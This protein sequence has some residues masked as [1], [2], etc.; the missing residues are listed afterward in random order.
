M[1]ARFMVVDWAPAKGGGHNVL[2]NLA[3]LLV[4]DVQFSSDKIVVVITVT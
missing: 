3:W 1:N 2:M 4:K